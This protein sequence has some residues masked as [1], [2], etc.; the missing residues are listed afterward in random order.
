MA[1]EVDLRSTLLERALSDRRERPNM[2][3]MILFK[4]HYQNGRVE[5]RAARCSEDLLSLPNVKYLEP[6]TLLEGESWGEVIKQGR[7]FIENRDE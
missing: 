4:V 2:I 3:D 6:L 5:K 7:D 1:E